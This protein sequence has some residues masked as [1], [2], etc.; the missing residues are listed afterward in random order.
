MGLGMKPF[1]RV[2]GLGTKPNT[3]HSEPFTLNPWHTL[4]LDQRGRLPSS[5]AAAATRC[6]ASRGGMAAGGVR[7]QWIARPLEWVRARVPLGGRL[8]TCRNG[9]HA[10]VVILLA[11]AQS[12]PTGPWA[13][14]QT[15][16]MLLHLAGPLLPLVLG[17]L[18][19]RLLSALLLAQTSQALP[20]FEVHHCRLAGG[21]KLRPHAADEPLHMRQGNEAND[22]SSQHV[23]PVHLHPP[24]RC[25]HLVE[26]RP[27]HP[28]HGL[29]RHRFNLK[30]RGH[31][32]P[33]DK[34]W[35]NFSAL[36]SERSTL[37]S[38]RV[39]VGRARRAAPMGA[40]GEEG[41]CLRGDDNAGCV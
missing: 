27:L 8:G 11:G 21:A 4:S 40:S 29:V 5:A 38:R 16:S 13:H 32:P 17:V 15:L 3:L 12:S 31:L 14:S 10:S 7:T 24:P 1:A 22:E 28:A 26:H 23:P 9:G 25:G 35:R 39:A 18:L 2:Q 19:S 30:P 20:L 34:S 33:L 6:L 37:V 36:L 41:G